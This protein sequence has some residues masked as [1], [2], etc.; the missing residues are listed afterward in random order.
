LVLGQ[1]KAAEILNI[2]RPALTNFLNGKS[3]L[4]MEM[5]ARLEKGFGIKKSELLQLKQEYDNSKIIQNAIFFRL[6]F[7]NYQKFKKTYERINAI[8]FHFIYHA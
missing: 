2:G 3:D 6:E 8:G 7:K 1:V 4:S 5:I